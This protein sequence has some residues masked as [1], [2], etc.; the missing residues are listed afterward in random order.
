MGQFQNSLP[1]VDLGQMLQGGDAF[2]RGPGPTVITGGSM[3]PI[4]GGPGEGGPPVDPFIKEI[5][6]RMG[7]NLNGPPRVSD[8]CS[9]D[10]QKFC[11]DKRPATVP[12]GFFPFNPR[13]QYLHCLSGHAAEITKPCFE[14]IEHTLPHLCHEEIATMCDDLISVGIL[15][16]M[17]KNMAKLKG[18]CLDAYVTTRHHIDAVKDATKI[19]AVHKPTGK[20]VGN[21]MQILEKVENEATESS[22][23]SLLQV[24]CVFGVFAGLYWFSQDGN[25]QLGKQYFHSVTG[26]QFEAQ[27]RGKADTT[28]TAPYGSTGAASTLTI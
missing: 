17:E 26:Y 19:D 14:K 18:K 5:L 13:T 28:S 21:L 10:V 12:G 23:S 6:G 24:L 16:C 2:G 25:I 7:L 1:M 27:P 9:A 20:M 4:G 8:A 3:I 11:P 22:R 15:D